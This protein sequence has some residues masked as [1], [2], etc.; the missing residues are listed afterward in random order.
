M[1]G[2]GGLL[3]RGDL[4]CFLGCQPEPLPVPLAVP[5]ADASSSSPPIVRKWDGDLSERQSAACN[6]T[7]LE[8]PDKKKHRPLSTDPPWRQI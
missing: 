1:V 2:V 6:G 4:F 8:M 3:T 7:A 5:L